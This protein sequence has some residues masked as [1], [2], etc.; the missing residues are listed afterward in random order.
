MEEESI[1]WQK[2]KEERA[3]A[4]VPAVAE[5]TNTSAQENTAADEPVDVEEEET[6]AAVN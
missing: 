2:F 1:W 3:A 6:I 4:N 5:A